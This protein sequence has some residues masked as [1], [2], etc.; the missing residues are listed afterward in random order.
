MHH[1]PNTPGRT[2]SLHL[3]TGAQKE[4]N[5]SPPWAHTRRLPRA[6][7]TAL[8][9]GE[10]Q[11]TEDRKPSK[12]TTQTQR[13][14]DATRSVTV[15][16]IPRPQDGGHDGHKRAFQKVG[17]MTGPAS[18]RRRRVHHASHKSP[19]S[20]TVSSACMAE[21]TC[22]TAQWRRS[23]GEERRASS[24]SRDTPST[25]T[26]RAVVSADTKTTPQQSRNSSPRNLQ[27]DGA[28]AESR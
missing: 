22:A 1:A 8:D 12:P 26:E 5:P 4:H 17:R 3:C 10:T 20:H 15:C 27:D 16:S 2:D 6:P 28:E 7:P 11:E 25:R 24:P 13:N 9:A 21:A 19:P 18:R 14:H 23:D